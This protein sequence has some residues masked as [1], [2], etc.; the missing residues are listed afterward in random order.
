MELG[1]SYFRKGDMHKGMEVL[2][3]A[4]GF[5]INPWHAWVRAHLY[6]EIDSLDKFFKYANYEPP[7]YA[8]P[9]YRKKITNPKVIQDPRYKQLMD[10]MNLPM[11][12]GY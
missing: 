7:L 1:I 8:A 11:P 9:W 2:Q 3:H 5:P 12:Q 6:A 10:K 4:L